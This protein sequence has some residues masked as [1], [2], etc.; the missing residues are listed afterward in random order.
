MNTNSKGANHIKTSALLAE[1][2]Q[3]LEG[4]QVSIGTLLA[5]FQ[6]RSYGGVMLILALLAMIPGISVFAGIAMIVPAF[7]LFIG[8]P[9]PVFPNFIQQRKISIAG[10]QKWGMKISGWVERLENLVVPRWPMLSN[11]LAQKLI[12]L[13]VLLLALVVAIPFPLSNFLP[14][15]ATICF[16]LGLLERDGLMIMLA[17]IVSIAAFAIGVA[18]FY[19]ALNWIIDFF[20]L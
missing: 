13:I 1:T 16:A 15:I 18:V 17:I 5:Q 7:Q 8:L 6:R 10:L 9:A 4:T 12:G 2:L 20:G 14:A 19:F 3:T 11:K